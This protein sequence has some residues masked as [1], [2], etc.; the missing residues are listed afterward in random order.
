MPEA[1]KPKEFVVPKEG[2]AKKCSF[3]RK[4]KAKEGDC[5]E[6]NESLKKVFGL[7]EDKKR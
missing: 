6:E 7:K 2:K 3:R 4:G 1:R 5:V